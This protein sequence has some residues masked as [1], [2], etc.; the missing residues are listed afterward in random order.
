MAGACSPVLFLK[1]GEG[2][3]EPVGDENLCTVVKGKGSTAAVVLCDAGGNAKAISA[4]MEE[5]TAEAHARS[6]AARGV[7]SFDGEVRLP[8]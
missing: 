7:A 6:L 8:I 1:M 5:A 2:A 3:W 4:W